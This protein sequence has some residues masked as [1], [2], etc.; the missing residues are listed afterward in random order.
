[1]SEDTKSAPKKPAAEAAVKMARVRVLKNR[2]TIRNFKHAEGSITTIPVDEFE[3]RRKAG[4]VE[5]LNLV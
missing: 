3:L 2:L 4:E 5:L 1:M